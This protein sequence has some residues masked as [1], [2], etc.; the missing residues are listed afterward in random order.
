MKVDTSA[1]V[2]VAIAKK[3]DFQSSFHAN[4]KRPL[5]TVKYNQYRIMKQRRV[6]ADSQR[7]KIDLD[8]NAAEQIAIEAEDN[9]RDVEETLGDFGYSLEN[10]FD[11]WAP[12]LERMADEQARKDEETVRK[13]AD[14]LADS[15]T[16]DGVSIREMAGDPEDWY[17]YRKNMARRMMTRRSGS[18]GAELAVEAATGEDNEDHAHVTID[19]P[20]MDAIERFMEELDATS[21]QLESDFETIFNNYAW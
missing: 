17:L 10:L 2:S 21:Q 8:L 1:E 20:A 3:A 11:E 14:L 4:M 16:I 13:I 15:V 5:S 9:K 7:V 19:I 12:R 18:L 6:M